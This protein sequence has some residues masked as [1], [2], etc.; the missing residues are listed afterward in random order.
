LIGKADAIRCSFGSFAGASST[1]N[2]STYNS[3][4]AICTGRIYFA[5]ATLAPLISHART[6]C[7]G[8]RINI[9]WATLRIFVCF[10]GTSS[11]SLVYFAR[12]VGIELIIKTWGTCSLRGC[13][14]RT[15]GG[16]RSF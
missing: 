15:A 1:K 13:F 11:I 2:I 4:R 8:E 7:Y 14:E 16:Q 12:A 10:A 3:A 5:W 9:A 6:I